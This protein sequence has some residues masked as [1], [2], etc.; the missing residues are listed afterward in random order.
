MQSVPKSQPASSQSELEQSVLASNDQ[1]PSNEPSPGLFGKPLPIYH[2]YSKLYLLTGPYHGEFLTKVPFRFNDC[3]NETEQASQERIRSGILPLRTMID[4]LHKQGEI[5]LCQLPMEHLTMNENG[6]V[7]LPEFG[8]GL[9]PPVPGS[10]VVAHNDR[11]GI[12]YRQEGVAAQG[13]IIGGMARQRNAGERIVEQEWDN[14]PRSEE[15]GFAPYSPDSP[16][17]PDFAQS[18]STLSSVVGQ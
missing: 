2:D 15:D 10:F 12:T 8:G 14:R 16:T 1:I 9:P 17:V 3:P 7:I 18:F 11:G 5:A 4:L 6:E 13:E